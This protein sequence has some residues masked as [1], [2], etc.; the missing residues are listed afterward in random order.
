MTM[1]GNSQKMEDKTATTFSVPAESPGAVTV[2]TVRRGEEL[3]DSSS[4]EDEI[5]GYDADRMRARTLLSEKEERKLMWKVDWHLMP[6]CSIMFL[7]KNMDYQN[8]GRDRC[9]ANDTDN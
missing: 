8:V 2:H 7:L 6:L 4:L 9:V 1:A 3:E 5:I